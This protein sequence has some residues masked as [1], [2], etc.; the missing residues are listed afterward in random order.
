MSP[1]C[2]R[3]EP[4]RVRYPAARQVVAETM[5]VHTASRRVMERSG[6]RLVRSFHQPWPDPIP[7]DEL[8]DVGYAN[9]RSEWEAGL[10]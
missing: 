8:G 6:M 10:A 1:V 3:L 4:L 2:L 5:A 7:G 9:E